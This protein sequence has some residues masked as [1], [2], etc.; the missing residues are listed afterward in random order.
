MGALRVSWQPPCQCEEGL[1]Q[2]WMLSGLSARLAY[3]PEGSIPDMQSIVGYEKEQ[4]GKRLAQ[5]DLSEGAKTDA[6]PRASAGPKPSERG[7]S[8]EAS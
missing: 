8:E 7:T 6:G 2:K 3:R 1:S 4:S 5:V